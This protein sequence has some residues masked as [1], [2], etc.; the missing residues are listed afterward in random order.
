MDRQD[1]GTTVSTPEPA[2]TR[3]QDSSGAARL[4]EVAAHNADELL[5]E[6][7]AEAATVVSAAQAE[8]DQLVMSAKMEAAR[9]RSELETT[10]NQQ[11]AE[12]ARLQQLADDH[13]N[14]MRSHVS[15]LLAQVDDTPTS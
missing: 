1:E 14:R 4:L 8:A 12:I 2:D 5:A 10:R 9:V 3:A 6:A 13:K 11:N 15:D 7:R